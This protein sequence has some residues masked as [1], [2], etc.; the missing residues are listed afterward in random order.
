MADYTSQ[1]QREKDANEWENK[2]IED[3]LTIKTKTEEKEMEDLKN[4]NKTEYAKKMEELFPFFSERYPTIF[5]G[6]IR[7]DYVED[8]TKLYQ[9][10]EMIN[11]QAEIRRHPENKEKIE[12]EYGITMA[13]RYLPNQYDYAQLV[14]NYKSNENPAKEKDKK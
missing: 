2:M 6:I 3:I 13:Q 14:K 10:S 5:M 9:L 7:G 4:N 8:P 11:K 12:T 1:K